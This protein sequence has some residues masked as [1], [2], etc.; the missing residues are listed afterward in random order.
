[1][2]LFFI[3]QREIGAVINELQVNVQLSWLSQLSP[4]ICSPSPHTHTHM[5]VHTHM[6]T[7]C[8]HTHAL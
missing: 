8:I 6:H 5:Y 2:V 3:F 7:Y 1:M 4:S